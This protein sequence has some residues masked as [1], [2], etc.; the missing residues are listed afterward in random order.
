MLMKLLDMKVMASILL[1]TCSFTLLGCAGTTKQEEG[2]VIGAVLGG[3]LGSEMGDDDRR[4]RR[5]MKIL[6]GALIGGMIGSEIGKYMDDTDRLKAGR[7]LEANP[8]GVGTTWVNPDSNYKY[9]VTPTNTYT[10]QSGPCRE[11]TTEAI[12][13]GQVE[14]VYGTACRQAD[15]SW[16]VQN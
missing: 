9:T 16:Q 10:A 13:G 14:T 1:L 3:V 6:V 4:G 11:Y 5:D 2:M 12:I 8:T 7:V 15:G